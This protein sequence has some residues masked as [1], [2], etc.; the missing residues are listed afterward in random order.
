MNRYNQFLEVDP[1]MAEKNLKILEDQTDDDFFKKLFPPE[2]PHILEKPSPGFCFKTKNINSGQKVFV[3]VC[4]TDVIP[5]PKDI[6]EMNFES[7]YSEYR[8]PLSI[9]DVHVEIDNKGDEVSVFDVAVNGKFYRRVRDDDSFRGFFF[10]VVLEGLK[11][12][13]KVHLDENVTTLK[14]RKVFGELGY[15]RINKKEVERVKRQYENPQIKDVTNYSKVEQKSTI[16][17]LSNSLIQEMPSRET[18]GFDKKLPEFR[19]F[20]KNSEPSCLYLEVSLPKIIS[21]SEFSLDVGEDRVV[22]ESLSKNYFMDIFLPVN[23]IQDTVE[24]LFLKIS[25]ILKVKMMV[26]L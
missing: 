5:P 3:N 8:I 26:D 20:K 7:E 10:S 11:E 15:H 4:Y 21:S 12:K 2:V 6:E 14:N 16:S 25:R 13:Y 22:L 23:V 18:F 24:A 9:G 17:T 1:A 19:L